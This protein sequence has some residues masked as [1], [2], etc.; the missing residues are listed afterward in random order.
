M[1][2]WKTVWKY[3]GICNW[4]TDDLTKIIYTPSN[5]VVGVGPVQ[6]LKT[7][8]SGISKLWKHVSMFFKPP[9][10]TF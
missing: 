4:F 9:S 6:G 1:F 10:A 2:Q 8:N 5:G 7:Q 3:L